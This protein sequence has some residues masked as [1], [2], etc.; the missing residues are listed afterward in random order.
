MSRGKY[1][2]SG[3]HTK[4]LTEEEEQDMAR[5]ALEKTNEGKELSWSK[6]KEIV[7]E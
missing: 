3:G 6:L 4:V 2:G 5:M 7:M 1:I